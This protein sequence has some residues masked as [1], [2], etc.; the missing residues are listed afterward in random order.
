MQNACA[1]NPE[2]IEAMGIHDDR[3]RPRVHPPNAVCTSALLRRDTI[4]ILR[5]HRTPDVGRSGNSP[6]GPSSSTPLDFR[7]LSVRCESLLDRRRRVH[8]LT[9]D[10]TSSDRGEHQHASS[11]LGPF[12]FCSPQQPA[13]S[14]SHRRSHG[15]HYSTRLRQASP[16]QSA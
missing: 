13:L 14:R 7:R 2:R 9:M 11:P 16:Q 3:E 5:P 8:P 4:D 10:G 12:F 1:G 15:T 6:G